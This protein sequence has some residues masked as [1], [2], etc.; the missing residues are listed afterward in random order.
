MRLNISTRLTIWYGLTLI[1]LLS[2]F[3]VFCYASFHVSLH[4]DFDRHLTHEERELLPFIQLEGSRPHFAS[5]EDVRSVAYRT[6]G[7]YGTY[8]RLL[9]SGGGVLYRSPN[10]AGHD[11]LPTLLPETS[12]E[13]IVSREWETNPART[14]YTP[15]VGNSSQVIGWLEVTGIEWSLHREL[16]RLGWT[17]GI[18]ILFSA[19]FAIAGGYWLARRALR[20]MATLTETA[21]QIGA[22]DLNARLPAD[23]GVRDELTELAETLNDLIGRLAASLSRERRLTANAAHELLTPLATLR[24]EIEVTLRRERDVP[25]YKKTLRGLIVEVEQLSTTLRRLLQLA[26]ADRM[27]SLRREP[28][29]FSNL[30]KESVERR[31]HEAEELL[32]TLDL[33]DE[34]DVTVAGEA[35][36]LREVIDNLLDNA[37]KYT[38]EGGAVTVEVE[39]KQEQAH[40]TVSDTGVG[41]EPEAADHLFDR[42]YR[43]DAP[44]V[45]AQPGAGLGLSIVRVIVERYG[46]TVTARNKS[47][48]PG[49]VFEVWLPIYSS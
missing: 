49:S 3:A 2:L 18:G 38:P 42:F 23:F 34:P 32:I 25:S 16:H 31:R 29:N 45:Q 9:S 30:T 48:S 37:L 5:L 14:H 40:L 11:E 46:G 12:E 17:L 1:V 21:R 22:T 39:K 15:L 20:P 36:Q 4:R 33:H 8:V 24:N 19:L 47:N 26:R 43:S 10:F 35:V 6:D 41:F 27:T 28:I 44:P 7:I 13:T